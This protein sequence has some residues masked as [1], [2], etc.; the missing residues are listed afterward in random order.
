MATFN[1]LIDRDGVV[2]PA[3]LEVLQRVRGEA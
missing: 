3:A 1:L 2:N